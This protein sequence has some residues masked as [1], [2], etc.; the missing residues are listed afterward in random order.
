MEAPFVEIDVTSLEVDPAAEA[1][2]LRRLLDK[3]PNC[4]M[5]VGADGEVLAANEASLQM[6][7]VELLAD[8]LGKPF[9]TWL[10]PDQ[11]AQWAAFS[12]QVIGASP[13][14]IELDIQAATGESR[15]VQF[16]GVPLTDHPDGI[17]SMALS[18][19]DA[20][21]R[22]KLER[23]LN[24]MAAERE[25]LDAEFEAERARVRQGLEALRAQ[26]L[27][28]LQRATRTAALRQA[29]ASREQH[30]AVL[31]GLE[32]QR[33]DLQAQLDQALADRQRV[34]SALADTEARLQHLTVEREADHSRFAR[35]LDSVVERHEAELREARAAAH[36]AATHRDALESEAAQDARDRERFWAA[37]EQSGTAL[38]QLTAERDAL[39]QKLDQSDSRGLGLAEA[40]RDAEARHQQAVEALARDAE[41][42]RSALQTRLD[43]AV[44]DCRRLEAAL[45]A[46]DA[47]SAQAPGAGAVAIADAGQTGLARTAA[48]QAVALHA[49]AEQVR[50]L[51]PLAAA[52]RVGSEIASE[53][54][55]LVRGADRAATRL[56]AACPIDHPH[57]PDVERLRADAIQAAAL[58]GELLHASSSPDDSVV[59]PRRTEFPGRCA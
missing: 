15:V 50:R 46:Q 31:R 5:R 28:E 23:S 56:L 45:H 32:S 11:H 38:G 16:H 44:M 27:A 2:H 12:A 7:G 22:R 9:T 55:R 35:D 53:L 19:R 58:A 47:G 42:A 20:M 36:Q 26:Y 59:A 14:S 13:A 41:L 17:T 21:A 57:R 24:E 10:P 37:I 3:Q 49:L 54:Q 6:L 30:E 8:A 39:Q 25:R 43:E 34:E 18:A 33:L 4:L 40:L 48:D 1:E 52:G 29:E 51:S